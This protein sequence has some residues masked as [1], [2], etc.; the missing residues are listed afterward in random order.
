MDKVIGFMTYVGHDVLSDGQTVEEF[1]SNCD[2]KLRLAEGNVIGGIE[3][4]A[5]NYVPE[6]GLVTV[7]FDRAIM[8]SVAE[9]LLGEDDLLI[10][11]N[12]LSDDTDI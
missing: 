11:G 1:C 7:L 2:I 9:T 3:M 8:K 6:S 12:F 10:F 4:T 5:V